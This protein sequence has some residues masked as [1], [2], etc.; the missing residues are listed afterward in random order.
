MS[1]LF[2]YFCLMFSVIKS[3]NEIVFLYEKF[4]KDIMNELIFNIYKLKS[5]NCKIKKE[6]FKNILFR[7]ENRGI[8]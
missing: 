6:S 4:S 8:H 3:L 5:V 2:Y 7:G 1:T